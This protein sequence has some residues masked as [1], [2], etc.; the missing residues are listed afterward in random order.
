MNSKTLRTILFFTANGFA[1]VLSAQDISPAAGSLS[2]SQSLRVPRT[3]IHTMASDEG[4][5]YGIWAAGADYKASFHDGATFVPYLGK[6]YPRNQSLRWSTSSARIGE[7]ELRTHAP[8]LSHTDFRAEYDLGGIVEAY[9]VRDEGLE[10]TFVLRAR[11]AATGDLIIT[12]AIDTALHAMGGEAGPQGIV[13]VDDSGR[14]I[15]NYGA[16]T[17]IDARGNS[18]AMRTTLVDGEISLRLDG[19]WL[20]NA[21]FP[22]TVDPLLGVFL[23]YGGVPLAD[24]DLAREHSLNQGNLWLAASRHAS[25]TDAD[26]W[27]I[28]TDD[29]GSNLVTNFTDLSASWSTSEASLGMHFTSG[30]GL[31]AFTREFVTGTRRVRYHLH[32]RNDNLLQTT[33]NNLGDNTINAWRPDVASDLHPIGQN[34][35][36][37]VYQSEGTGAPFVDLPTSSISGCE[38]VLTGTGTASL[39]FTIASSPALDHARPTI[40]KV[41]LGAS[42]VWTVAY[43]VIDNGLVAGGGHPDWDVVVRRV[44]SNG[45]VSAAEFSTPANDG[46]H[47]MAPRIA[48][49]NNKHVVVFT[50]SSVLDA[51]PK[52]MSDNGHV[53]QSVRLDWNGASFERPYPYHFV[54]ANTDPRLVLTGFDTDRNSLDFY[55]LT[56]RSTAT[57]AV[58]LR[59]LG[60]SAKL[61]QSETVFNPTGNEYSGGGAVAFDEDADQF[62]IAFERTTP[63]GSS[64]A[65]LVRY[66]YT[67]AVA[68]SLAGIGCGT[69]QISWQGPQLIGG[70]H[71][72][73][74]ITNV[75]AGALMTVAMAIQPVA[76]PLI[77]VPG[78]HSGCWL[79]VPNT[80]AGSLGFLPLQFGPDGT[81][82]LSLPEWLPAMTLHFQGFHF[83]AGNTEVFTTQRLEVPIVH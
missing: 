32:S 80:G 65:R 66:A 22:V 81:W 24:F 28:R 33:V 50:R 78:V 59:M 11:P 53:I 52:P 63:L 54:Q 39:P 56:F 19:N 68:P 17:A 18:T 67:S 79:L 72:G 14:Q 16:A 83:D 62:V 42:Q 12:G 60:Y 25:A 23:S 27:M 36:V 76:T 41:Q 6:D 74:G 71:S 55:A 37:V 3:P 43:Q 48:G 5:A 21:A 4:H 10:Q 69:G 8:R 15:L 20:A 64:D 40:A 2:D 73:I 9:D 61:V 47:Q 46:Q 70:E 58:Y 26:L 29:D 57:E 45:N 7:L 1:V 31:L 44:D 49:F 51:G 38:V 75:P 13:F 82:N 30:K 77:G 35:L 34:S